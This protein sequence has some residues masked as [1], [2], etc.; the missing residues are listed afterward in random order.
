MVSLIKRKAVLA[1]AAA[2]LFLGGYPLKA[3]RLETLSANG[4]LTEITL[5][6]ARSVVVPLAAPAAAE[7]VTIKDTKA[8]GE[9]KVYFVDVGQGD[10][11]YIEL[12]NG[13]NVL[14]DGGPANKE[15]GPADTS[16]PASDPPL[17]HFLLQ[18]GV[19]KIDHVVLTHPHADHY[20]GLRYV[21]TKLPVGNFY[22]TR[23]D[24]PG[25]GAVRD[26]AAKV[27][28]INIFYP[29]PGEYLDWGPQVQAKVF[30]SCPD[31]AAA[32]AITPN[33]CSIV[34][35]LS[36]QD[37]SVLFTGDMEAAVEA[38]VVPKYG[39]ELRSD[40]LKVGHHG[41]AGAS[42][43]LFLKAVQPRLAFIE[44]GR[45]NSYGHP[46]PPTLARLQAAG[47]EIHRT[48][49]EG[50]LDFPS[51]A[52]KAAAYAAPAA[53]APGKGF[54]PLVYDEVRGG[55]MMK[56]VSDVYNGRKLPYAQDGVTFQNKEGLLPAMPAGYYKEYTLIT[57]DAPHTVKIGETVYQVSPD[58]GKRG[59]ER[60]VI[61]GGEK[62]YYSPDHYKTFILL[63]V[64]Y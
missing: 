62:I 18:K 51:D 17:A 24:N 59:A 6:S 28:G 20:V 34:V 36:Y 46:R 43:E 32:A 4:G 57:G 47:A 27:P 23:K 25:V 58:L 49:L 8:G 42:S 39:A 2:L 15:G 29:A 45:N 3:E 9:L 38:Q 16:H 26:L 56:L 12:P 21:F 10:A 41:S 50:T 5:D 60:I 40:V 30:N 63:A 55:L 7:T 22:D 52:A 48:D 33:N 19:K 44:V 31:A 64:A 11:Q 54:S 1:A 61:G 14:I 13:Q 53:P 35:K 37:A